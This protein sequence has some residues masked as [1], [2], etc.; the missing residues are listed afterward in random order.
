MFIFLQS[1]GWLLIPILLI[2]GFISLASQPVLLATVQDHLPNH[3]AL[4]NGFYLALGFIARPIATVIIGALGDGFGLQTAF[5]VA[6]VVGLLTFPFIWRLPE[7][8]SG[9]FSLMREVG[10][11]RKFQGTPFNR[12]SPPSAQRQSPTLLPPPGPLPHQRAV[13]Q[14]RRPGICKLPL[15]HRAAVFS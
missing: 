13:F 14:A 3:R 15:H 7:V 9:T 12:N 8:P 10:S 2:L 6:T 4:G 1:D 11:F 5:Y